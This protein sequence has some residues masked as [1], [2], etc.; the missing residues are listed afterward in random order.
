MPRHDPDQKTKQNILETAMR[1]FAEKGLENV[2]VEDVVKEVGVTRG[3]FYH[4]F[5]SRE[6]LIAGVM[7]KSFENDN[8][9]L[10]ADKQEGLNAL[11]K[12]R[13]VAKNSLRAHM[14]ISD[15]MRTQMEKL[16]NNPVVFKNEMLFQINVMAPYMEKLLNEGNKDGSMNVVYP[17]QASQTILW[18]TASWLT[19]YAFKVSYEEYVD[20]ILFFEQLSAS[21]GVPVMDE[22][23]KKIYMTIARREFK[24]E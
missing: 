20:K 6:E 19:P 13:F 21:L 23:M 14:D 4:Y 5:K 18:L 3:A 22:E 24:K 7:Y 8:P 11:E 15:S 1:L 9:Y 16:A 10:L 2:N 12:L 17:K